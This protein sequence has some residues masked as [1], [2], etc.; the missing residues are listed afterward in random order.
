MVR[1][2]SLAGCSKADVD[3]AVAY[4]EDGS[5]L[6]AYARIFEAL[7]CGY[8]AYVRALREA[9]E[10][11]SRVYG[12]QIPA[13]DQFFTLHYSPPRGVTDPYGNLVENRQ[14][15]IRFTLA[16]EFRDRLGRGEEV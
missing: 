12:Q 6:T 13:D 11:E 16:D 7:G 1:P 8:T 9:A 15:V 4:S 14:A 10:R 3:A 2:V 5:I